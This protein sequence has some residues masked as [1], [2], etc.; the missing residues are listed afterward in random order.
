MIQKSSLPVCLTAAS[1]GPRCRPL[2]PCL[3]TTKND[4]YAAAAPG[5]CDSGLQNCSSLVGRRADSPSSSLSHYK[6]NSPPAPP[7]VSGGIKGFFH[8]GPSSEAL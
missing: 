3:R 4:R 5:S 2:H 7:A 6:P 1:S 8:V